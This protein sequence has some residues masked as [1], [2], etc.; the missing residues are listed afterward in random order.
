MS[1]T[2][3]RIFQCIVWGN[4]M[5]AVI[6]VKSLKS[7]AVLAVV[8]SLCVGR[9]WLKNE[10]V[11]PGG[12]KLAPASPHALTYVIVLTFIKRLLKIFIF[13]YFWFLYNLF[14]RYRRKISG[15]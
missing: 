2:F 15:H 11:A 6:R 12:V 5:R 9:C 4:L 7:L 1:F 3:Q 13:I 8:Q 14:S 10:L